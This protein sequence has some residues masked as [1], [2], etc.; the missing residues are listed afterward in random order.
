[1]EFYA[2]VALLY[3]IKAGTVAL[4][5]GQVETEE[6]VAVSV[7]VASQTVPSSCHILPVEVNRLA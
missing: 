1:M 7:L 4:V 3:Q 2:Q 6:G 5:G